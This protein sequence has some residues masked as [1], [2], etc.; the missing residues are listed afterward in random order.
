M[1]RSIGPDLPRGGACPEF[2][3]TPVSTTTEAVPGH[4]C[5]YMSCALYSGFR[6]QS[7]EF[8]VQ[9]LRFRVRGTGFRVSGVGCRVNSRLVIS[10]VGFQN[11]GFEIRDSVF[12]FWVS[13]FGFQVRG[14]GFL[15]SCF[16][17]RVLKFRVSD[18]E[19]L[20]IQI[21]S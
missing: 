13:G 18:L 11:T 9:G 6:V 19:G 4:A 1:P 20:G 10:G 15:V 17:S 7:S 21:S 16:L 2:R 8:R 3:V 14:L 12:G 5:R